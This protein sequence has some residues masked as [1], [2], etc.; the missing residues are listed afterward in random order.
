MAASLSPSSFSFCAW[1]LKRDRRS[2]LCHKVSTMSAKTAPTRVGGGP[3]LDRPLDSTRGICFECGYCSCRDRSETFRVCSQ[4]YLSTDCSSSCP[5]SCF[6][7]PRRAQPGE[8][9]TWQRRRGGH[10]GRSVGMVLR[11]ARCRRWRALKCGFGAGS[12]LK[13]HGTGV[14][15]CCCLLGGRDKC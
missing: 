5:C 14:R 10:V 4:W 8:K 7:W 3:L 15:E 1:V 2:R 13:R 11:R 9:V 12:E 6:L